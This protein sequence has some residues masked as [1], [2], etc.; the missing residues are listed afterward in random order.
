VYNVEVVLAAMCALV[1]FIP[2]IAI[3]SQSRASAPEFKLIT[4]NMIVSS[5]LFVIC[6][7]VVSVIT[8][9]ILVGAGAGNVKITSTYPTY[10]V[11]VVLGAICAPVEFTPVIAIWSQSRVL[12]SEFAAITPA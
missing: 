4:F 10:N 5:E 3:W 6:P 2:V 1:E 7:K 9:V 12:A 11:E 8:E